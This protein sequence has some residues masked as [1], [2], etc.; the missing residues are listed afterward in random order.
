MSERFVASYVFVSVETVAWNAGVKKNGE[1]RNAGQFSKLWVGPVNGEGAP[2]QL[3]LPDNVDPGNFEFEPG[4]LVDIEQELETWANGQLRR[5]VV[6]IRE[7]AA[8]AA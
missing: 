4:S 6:R 2:V 3:A 7:S 8:A 5:R 1:Q